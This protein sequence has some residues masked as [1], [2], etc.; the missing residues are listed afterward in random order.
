MDALAVRCNAALRCVL[1]VLAGGPRCRGRAAPFTVVDSTGVSGLNE[2]CGP[3]L[4][5]RLSP[6]RERLVRPTW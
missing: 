2:I 3:R 1:V 6:G 4:P 5:G